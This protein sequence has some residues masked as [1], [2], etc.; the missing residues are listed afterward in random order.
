M[1]TGGK[2]VLSICTPPWIHSAGALCASQWSLGSTLR[3]VSFPSLSQLLYFSTMHRALVN[4]IHLANCSYLHLAY[5]HLVNCTHSSCKL[6]IP[7]HTC[8]QSSCKLL[9]CKLSLGNCHFLNCIH[10][11]FLFCIGPFNTVSLL[12]VQMQIGRASLWLGLISMGY[13]LMR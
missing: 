8:T 5:Y 12:V 7:T 6:F 1:P 4:C 10:S 9:S 13:L 11:F 3:L 2:R